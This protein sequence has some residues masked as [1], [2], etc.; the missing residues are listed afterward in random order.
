MYALPTRKLAEN[1][2]AEVI[3][4]KIVLKVRLSA[5]IV[6]AQI[7]LVGTKIVKSTRKS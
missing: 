5:E 7:T 1:V 6:K 2:P 3:L 4:R